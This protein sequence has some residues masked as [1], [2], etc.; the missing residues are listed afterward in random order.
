MSVVC[1]QLSR[2]FEECRHGKESMVLRFAQAEKRSLDLQERCQ[3]AEQQLNEW[4]SERETAVARWHVMKAEN[5]QAA[6]SLEARVC[7]TVH[8][9]C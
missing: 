5:S 1:L 2:Q 4:W 7:Y 9:Y 8:V 6:Q 3:R